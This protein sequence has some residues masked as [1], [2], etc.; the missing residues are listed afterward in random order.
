LILEKRRSIIGFV[1]KR[2]GCFHDRKCAKGGNKRVYILF[3]LLW[4]IFN[5]QITLEIVIFGLVIAA[6]MY[7]FVC[8]FMDFSPENDIA[9]VKKAPYLIQYFC[10]LVREIVVANFAAM[11]LVLSSKQEIEP[12]IVQ[13]DTDLKTS[14]S[15][16]LLANSI[17]LTPGTITVAIDGSRFTVHCLDKSL[18]E[19]MEDSVFVHILRKIESVE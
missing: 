19:G 10:C 3:F 17:T 18:S 8:K 13:F 12:C 6:A 15:K 11:R 1:Q 16:V 9:Y 2:R 4:I 5:G 14:A 7:W